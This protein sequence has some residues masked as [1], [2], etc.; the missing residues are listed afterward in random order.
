MGAYASVLVKIGEYMNLVEF[1][2]EAICIVDSSTI[3]SLIK[4]AYDSGKGKYRLCMHSDEQSMLHGSVIV[5]TKKDKSHFIHKH[6]ETSE[7]N[8]I[9]KGRLLIIIF[10]ENGNMIQTF[11]LE[12]GKMFL[13]RIEK[14]LYHLAVPL[15][16]EAVFFEVKQGPFENDKNVLPAW[17]EYR[18][19]TDL[20][21]EY[22]NE[23]VR[24]ALNKIKRRR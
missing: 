22:I 2:Q 3:E 7:F 5:T 10:D 23:V 15:S 19:N 4:K 9:I 20:Y 11:V 21:I 18:I 6:M 14:N 1:N 17:V 13:V 8:M 16:D 24:I 12:E